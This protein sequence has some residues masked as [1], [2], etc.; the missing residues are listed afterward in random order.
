MSEGEQDGGLHYRTER[1][2]EQETQCAV[3]LFFADTDQV[4]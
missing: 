4:S 3:R 2:A 1:E